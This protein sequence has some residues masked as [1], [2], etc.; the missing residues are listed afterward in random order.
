M[1]LR[2]YQ[3]EA[4]EATYRYLRENDG[5]PA[6]VLPTASG[7]TLVMSTIC[8]DAVGQWNGRV[9]ILAHVKELL[10]QTAAT[11]AKTSPLFD[12]GVYSAGLKSRDTEHSIIV[13]GIQSVYKRAC[14]LGSFDLIMVDEAHLIPPTGEG[15]YRTFLAEA[16]VINPQV[17]LIGLTATPY[18]M[19][20][21]MICG[22]DNLLNEI[23]YEISVKELI[24]QGF[25]CQL[26]SRAGKVKA[27]TSGL[28]IRGGEFVANEVEELMDRDNLV[29]SACREIVQY[30]HD[31]HS[32][33]IF[34][35]GVQHGRHIRRV[36][37]ALGQECGFV[38]GETLPFDR[39]E[40]LKRFRD[41]NLKYL[42]NVNVLTTGFDAPNIDCVVILRPTN[43]PGLF[44]QMTG[45]GFRLHPSKP[46]CLILDYG[47]NILRHGP[48]DDL[49][50]KEP[51]QGS[52]DA[53]A[54]ECPECNAVIH[55][56]YANCPE[57]NYEFPPPE[58]QQH[59]RQASTAGVLTGQVSIET[60]P[61]K[62]VNYSVHLK[63]NAPPDAPRTMRVEY[64]TGFRHWQSEWICFEHGG[65]AK[66]KAELWW[67]QRSDEPVPDT[68]EA[69]VA[70]AQEGGLAQT[71]AIE[72]RSVT[73]EKYKG[74][75][76]YQLGEKPRQPGWDDQPVDQELEP[77]NIWDDEEVPF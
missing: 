51:G 9:L 47:G 21:G 74:I 22:P 57:C 28:H 64:R 8:R 44:Y 12:V 52:G 20:T 10:E 34:A 77:A 70:I 55:A 15:M 66:Y 13:A 38:C 2:P 11:L 75:V 67:K 30:T 37:E 73:G 19:S 4:V 36:L 7:K 62:E 58:R 48:V 24:V 60:F 26:K 59:D 56:A 42:C 32:A 72:V 43:S 29:R 25:L 69:A 3:Q 31:R 41:G 49:L 65:Y 50:I 16:K 46:D 18:R 68:A 61:V 6:I 17:R 14:E 53:P 71:L 27:D 39:A 63:R 54:K 45:R 5:N 1:Q 23:C 76:G 40:T 35:S 33:L